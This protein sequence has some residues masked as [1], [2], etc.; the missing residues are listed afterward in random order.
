[1]TVAIAKWVPHIWIYS[2]EEEVRQSMPQ[3]RSL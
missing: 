3:V 2:L 1:M